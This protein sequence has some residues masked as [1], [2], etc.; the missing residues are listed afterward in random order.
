[1]GKAG[2][3]AAPSVRRSG[4]GAYP[5]SERLEASRSAVR[6]RYGAGEGMWGVQEPWTGVRG[7]CHKLG[8]DNYLKCGFSS[9]S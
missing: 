5:R 4:Q 8:C 1:M 9:F 2:C 6:R 7:A 3:G